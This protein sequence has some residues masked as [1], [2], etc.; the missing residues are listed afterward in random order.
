MP[1]QLQ[2]SRWLKDGF[3]CLVERTGTC[4]Y[5]HIFGICCYPRVPQIG[6]HCYTLGILS[7]KPRVHM[8]AGIMR[9]NTALYVLLVGA[10]A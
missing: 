5:R 1:F 4:A 6:T 7:M 3:V 2:A 10:G 8:H 9:C